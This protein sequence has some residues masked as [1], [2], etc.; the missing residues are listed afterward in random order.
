MKKIIFIVIF[1][2]IAL[3]PQEFKKTGT[4]GFTFLEIPVSARTAALGESSIGLTDM[5]S[6]G[7]F[8]NPALLGFSKREHSLSL[9]Y[10]PWIADIKHYAASYSINTAFG[11]FGIGAVQLDYGTFTHTE[12]PT[13]T[14]LGFY[15]ILGTYKADALAIGIAYSKMLTDKFSFGVSFKYVRETI[16]D[17]TASNLLFDGGIVYYTGLGSLRVAAVIQNFGVE[18]KFINDPFKMP[19]VLK[20]GVA[21][22]VFGGYGE[23]YR[24]TVSA[25]ALHPNDND[26][27]VNL[28][29]E[30]AWNEMIVLRG[31]YKFFYDEETYSFGLGL[32]P[33]FAVP[34]NV[35]FAYADYGRL[36]D[37]LRFTVQFGL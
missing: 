19:S 12:V 28:G 22:E 23:E 27:R 31:G 36:G 3:H 5:N 29:V 1:S 9:S 33:N 4:S 15:N 24:V 6:D 8:V 35:D 34:F 11:V 30:A 18:A 37:V 10:A 20:L 25:E 26:E 17:Y 7:I 2:V 32:N 21:S 14:S 13:N 16:Y